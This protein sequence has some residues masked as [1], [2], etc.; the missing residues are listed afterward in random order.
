MCRCQ[1][2]EAEWSLHGGFS[3]SPTRHRSDLN[4]I[5][6]GMNFRQSDV[7]GQTCDF[8]LNNIAPSVKDCILHLHDAMNM[9]AD[10]ASN[11]K[12]QQEID[13]YLLLIGLYAVKSPVLD[14]IDPELLI[15]YTDHVSIM[16]TYDIGHIVRRIVMDAEVNDKSAMFR[17]VQYCLP[18]IKHNRLTFP[19]YDLFT[20]SELIALM[21]ICHATCMGVYEHANRKPTWNNRMCSF[22]MHW[23]IMENGNPRDMYCYCKQH[24]S[25]LRLCIIEYFIYF[26]NNNMPAERVY[27][28][29]IL[30]LSSGVDVIFRQ[31][32]CV[33]DNFR[34][35]ALQSV[36]FDMNSINCKAQAAIEK[37]NRICK[38]KTKCL[39]RRTIVAP[40]PL[41]REVIS[42]SLRKPVS[43]CVLGTMLHEQGLSA[44][45]A[46]TIYMIHS[47]FAVVLLPYNLYQMQARKIIAHGRH[48]SK[49]VHAS[50]F[51]YYC[52]Y[53]Q[54]KNGV[55]ILN[56]KMRIHGTHVSC[57][58]CGN[59][60]TILKI[61]TAGRVINIHNTSF[62]F[63]HQCLRIHAW[64][65]SNPD[66]FSCAFK[67]Q[68]SEQ[69]NCT[70]EK[71]LLCAKT[72]NTAKMNV[73]DDQL[74]LIQNL[75]LCSFHTPRE[76]EK[77]V[78]YNLD[79]F[80]KYISIRAGQTWKRK[81]ASVAY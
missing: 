50:L 40:W 65:P 68:T 76:H 32:L 48:N 10:A 13:R 59:N 3:I 8:S 38:G 81:T 14:Q 34:Q 77:H 64:D 5:F 63:C 19:E 18:Y 71:C 22:W 43:T 45:S 69:Q 33:I 57:V 54:E 26:V 39:G 17:I 80:E 62:Y 72:T 30:G 1:I 67:F 15:V 46:K 36:E 9:S 70:V 41:D 56:A 53:C 61:N 28:E 7:M 20:E 52:V 21:Q 55:S 6:T 23:R 49:G 58:K 12:T 51:L 29:K 2:H 75:T 11:R 47:Q 25:L 42:A 35:S 37:C 27:M 60:D 74:G 31:F 66:I 44:C 78:I 4:L 16:P 24:Q 79:S 73:L